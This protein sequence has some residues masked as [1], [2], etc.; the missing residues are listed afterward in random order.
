VKPLLAGEDTHYLARWIFFRVLGLVFLSAFASLVPQIRGLV[1]SHGLL[2]ASPYLTL[3]RERFGTLGGLWYAPTVFW[4]S[5][6]DSVLSALAWAGILSSSL[7]LVN[8]WPRGTLAVSAVLFLSFIAVLQDFSSYQSDGMLLEAAL[9]SL[10]LAPPGLLPGLGK[11]YPGPFLARAVLLWEWFRIY[12]ESGLAKLLSGDLQ[13]R[14]LTAMD[15]YYENGPLPTWIA[16][17]VQQLPH[18]FHAA[19]AFFILAFECV[20]VFG[21]FLP[22]PFRLLAFAVSTA[23]QLGIEATAN[24]TFLNLLVLG[25]GFLLLEDRDFRRP[26]ETGP[27]RP[28]NRLFRLLAGT[29]LSLQI[30]GTLVLFPL[31]PLRRLPG[32][33]LLPV[34]ALEPFRVAGRYGLFAVMTPERDEI[35]FQGSR[36][37]ARWVPYP[38]RFKP[39]G[40]RDAPGIYAPYHPRFEWNLW[41]ASLGTWEQYPWVETTEERLL[42]GERDVLRLFAA[43]PFSGSPPSYVKAVTARYSFTSV[44]ERRATGAYW[45]RGEERLYGPVLHSLGDGPFELL[46]RP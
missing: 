32:P 6:A 18:P 37:G 21:A 44:Q 19:T 25:L 7:L 11:E 9:A 41:F 13:W 23:L 20:L 30:Y 4:A 40:L 10:F 31:S 24:Y 35:E 15:H 12:F 42:S 8:V 34:V 26:V 17:W 3:V 45:K 39:Q 22:R 16:W 33:L 28:R 1:G 5:S 14:H 38:F 36:D 46:D 2:P 43:D 27:P 29:T